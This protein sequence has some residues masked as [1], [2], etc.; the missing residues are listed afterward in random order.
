LV[1][2]RRKAK[3]HSKKKAKAMLEHGGQK[4]RSPKA[5]VK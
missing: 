2:E 5:M 1:D 4:K 3:S